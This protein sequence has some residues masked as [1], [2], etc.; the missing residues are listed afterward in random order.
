MGGAYQHMQL[1]KTAKDMGLITYV[2]DYLPYEASPAKQ[3]ADYG[4]M[5]NITDIE[6][7]ASLCHKEHID[8]IVAPYLDVTQKP[9]QV[10]CERM[11]FPCFGDKR[12]HEIL[13]DKVLFKK[14]CR[15]NGLDV[16]PDYDVRDILDV[17]KCDRIV[18]FPILIKPCDSR[19]SRGQSICYTREEALEGIKIAKD[20][21]KSGGILIEKYMNS[22]DDLQLV[23]IVVNGEPILVRVEDRY[24]GAEDSGL[25]RL[26]IASINSSCHEEEYRLKTD[27]KAIAMIKAL[28]LKNAP[29]FIQGFKDGDTV[30]FY[31]PGLRLPGDG[32]DI[33]YKAAVGID[34]PEILITFALTGTIS[35]SV[36]E[37]I[38]KARITKATAMIEPCI[39]QGKISSIKGMDQI[40][41]NPYILSAYNAYKEGDEVGL[42]N[43]VRQRFGEYVIVCENFDELRQTIDWLFSTLHVYDEGGN[44]MLFAKFNSE[45]LKKY[46]G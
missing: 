41:K 22:N 13:T 10:L 23:Y 28:G 6:Q 5:Y 33:A 30:R 17:D 4:Y 27:Y 32:F 8:G 15:N 24:L 7:I 1:V 14:F 39:H 43:D 34:L 37:M 25:N 29:V 26:C 38:R 11:G 44:E 9:Y 35:D 3:M 46:F 45:N 19:G 20:A 16:I 40:K 31:D 2:T 36:G 42:Y 21:S 18:S 12:Q